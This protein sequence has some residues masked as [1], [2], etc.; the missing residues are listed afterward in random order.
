MV[1]PWGIEAGQIVLGYDLALQ[2]FYAF[3]WQ[4]KSP[5]K[6]FGRKHQRITM[7]RGKILSKKLIKER[8]KSSKG[9]LPVVLKLVILFQITSAELIFLLQY[10]WLQSGQKCIFTLRGPYSCLNFCLLSD[11][12][13]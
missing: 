8:K 13:I 12:F 4:C 2:L 1:F 10:L 3:Q 6:T 11:D 5:E 9:F 7:D